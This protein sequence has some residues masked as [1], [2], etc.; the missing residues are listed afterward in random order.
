MSRVFLAALH[1]L[2][3][4]F[5]IFAVHS[6]ASALRAP[7][8]LESLRRAFRADNFWALSAVLLLGSGLWRYLGGVE[9][10]TE[11]YNHNDFFLAKITLL[12]AI[13]ALE[14]W[15]MLTLIRWRRAIGRGAAP[16]ATVTAADA[17]RISTISYV[18]LVLMVFMVIAATAMARGFGEG[19]PVT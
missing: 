14:L 17:R 12:A 19:G 13:L 8:A 16:E 7:V 10:R 6:R 15:P 4:A 2:A 18:Q 1:L 9:K 3:F 5:A 11:Y